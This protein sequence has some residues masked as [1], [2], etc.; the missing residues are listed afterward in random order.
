MNASLGTPRIDNATLSVR[1]AAR[2]DASLG[3]E[4]SSIR[5]LPQVRLAG[6]GLRADTWP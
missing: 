3:C 6:S 5:A 2:L 4:V 1:E